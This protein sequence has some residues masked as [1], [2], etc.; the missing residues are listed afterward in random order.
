MCQHL[1]A[2]FAGTGAA[3]DSNALPP[4][5]QTEPVAGS[6]SQQV[7]GT[8]PAAQA[9]LTNQPTAARSAEPLKTA[10]DGQTA[11]AT[12]ADALQTAGAVAKAGSEAG[13]ATSSVTRTP[14]RSI[15]SQA[16]T[17]SSLPAKRYI[18]QSCHYAMPCVTG[19]ECIRPGATYMGRGFRL[20]WRCHALPQ[21]ITPGGPCMARV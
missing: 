16:T 7:P 12:T 11:A 21:R 8:E 2:R 15:D 3:A 20:W 17:P 13:A 9:E 19:G 1:H 4:T 10:A 14:D 5:Q 18:L 6:S